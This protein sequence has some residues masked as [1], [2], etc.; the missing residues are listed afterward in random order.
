MK[1]PSQA[2]AQHETKCSLDFPIRRANVQMYIDNVQHWALANLL[3]LNTSNSSITRFHKR[4]ACKPNL[5]SCQDPTDCHKPCHHLR[6]HALK[7][8]LRT[9]CW[10]RH[11]G[12]ASHWL[13]ISNHKELRAC[14]AMCTLHRI[15]PSLILIL[16]YSLVPSPTS[17]NQPS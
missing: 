6:G 13:H 4:G 15:G 5:Q 10:Y 7:Q 8:L 12:F 17:P 2:D 16:L 3:V 1:T 9:H 14:G 11:Y